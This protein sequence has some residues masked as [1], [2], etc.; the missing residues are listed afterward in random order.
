MKLT[1]AQKEELEYYIEVY[2][3]VERRD[4]LRHSFWNAIIICNSLFLA[5]FAILVAIFPDRK[6]IK[7][8]IPFLWIIIIPITSCL[9][10]HCLSYRVINKKNL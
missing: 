1:P 3:G 8:F 6:Q 10:N 5:S 2:K 4:S 7:D 9:F